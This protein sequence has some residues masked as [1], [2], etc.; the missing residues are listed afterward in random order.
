MKAKEVVKVEEIV[1]RRLSEGERLLSG[2]KEGGRR[3]LFRARSQKE[4]FTI[5][6]DRLYYFLGAI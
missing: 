1:V 3:E 4:S 6:A 2:G 5:L